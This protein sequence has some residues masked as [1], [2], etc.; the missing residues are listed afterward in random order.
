MHLFNLGLAQLQGEAFSALS[1]MT[2]PRAKDPLETEANVTELEGEFRML[3]QLLAR[4]RLIITSSQS[5]GVYR[6]RGVGA[7]S[8]LS[9]HGRQLWGTQ[10]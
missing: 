9:E 6:R 5:S 8:A 2:F 10:S 4:A 1:A 3:K 7:H